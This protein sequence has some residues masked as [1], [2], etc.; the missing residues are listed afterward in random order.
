MRWSIAVL[1]LVSTLALSSSF[2]V[3]ERVKRQLPKAGQQAGKAGQQALQQ[4][5]Q[6]A[7]K[8]GQQA[9]QQAAQQAGKAGQQAGQQAAKAGQQAGQQAAKAGQQAGQ[10]AAKAGQQAGQ[11][12]GKAGQQ[13]GQQAGKAGQQAGQQAGKAGQQNAGQQAG[14]AGQQAGKQTVFKQHQKLNSAQAQQAFRGNL[15][16]ANQGVYD[17]MSSNK[18]FDMTKMGANDAKRMVGKMAKM[19]QQART[20]VENIDSRVKD[21][22][23]DMIKK[24]IGLDVLA[25]LSDNTIKDMGKNFT[26]AQTDAVCDKMIKQKS[27]KATMKNLL[28]GVDCLSAMDRKPTQKLKGGQ[29]I[30]MMDVLRGQKQPSQWSANDW[31]KALRMKDGIKTSDIKNMGNSQ[32]KTLVQGGSLKGVQ[33]KDNAQKKALDT[34]IK[35]AFGQPNT[36]SASTIQQMASG[37]TLGRMSRDDLKKL[38]KANIKQAASSLKNTKFDNP[39]KKASVGKQMVEAFDKSKAASWSASDIQNLGP[40]IRNDPKSVSKMSATNFK[41]ALPT[42]GADKTNLRQSVTMSRKIKKTSGYNQPKQLDATKLG[43][44]GNFAQGLG[45]NFLKDL[46]DNAV[47]GAL[48]KLKDVPFQRGDKRVLMDKIK[49]GNSLGA[50]NKFDGAKVKQ[51]G[52]LVAGL[53]AKDLKSIPDSA[54]DDALDDLKTNADD[55]DKAQCHAIVAKVKKSNGDK[56]GTK[57]KK[58]GK[59]M[60]KCVMKSTVQKIDPDDLDL[61]NDTETLDMTPSKGQAK[62]LF[63][64]VK[65]RLGDIK[66][67]ANFTTGIMRKLGKILSRGADKKDIDDLTADSTLPTVVEGLAEDEDEMDEAQTKAVSKKI[68]SFLQVGDDT[69]V[70]QVDESTV[71][72]V[73]KFMKH[74]NDSDLSRFNKTLRPVIARKIGQGCMAKVKRSD[75]TRLKNFALKNV[76]RDDTGSV[77]D[78]RNAATLDDNDVRD[79]GS[80]AC[81]LEE[82]DVKKLTKDALQKNLYKLQKCAFARKVGK[83]LF[84]RAKSQISDL[85]STKDNL[86]TCGALLKHAAQADL[87]KIDDD[88]MSEATPD[89]V[90]A[91]EEQDKARAKRDKGGHKD[92]ESKTDRD[93][94]KKGKKRVAAKALSALKKASSDLRKKRSTT[95]T[96]CDDLKAM[97]SSATSVSATDLGTLSNADFS[98]CAETL[99]ALTG[100]DTDQL[101]TLATKAK[102]AWGAV[103]TWTTEQVRQ[104]GSIIGGLASSE[105]STLDL[106]SNDAMASIGKHA[107][108]SMQLSAGFER[109]LSQAKSGSTST[110][111]ASELST[112]GH[113]ACGATTTHINGFSSSVYSDAASSIGALTTCESSQL[114]AYATKAKTAFGSDVTSWTTGTISTMGAVIGGLAKTDLAQ[115]SSD[116]ISAISPA[117]IEQIPPSNFAGF[118]T[119]QLSGLTTSQANAVTAQQQN[120]LSAEQRTSL[121]SAG[122]TYKVTDSGAAHVHVSIMLMLTMLV[123]LRL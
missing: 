49:K 15:K 110:V 7:G 74:F 88:V 103:N 107:F 123:F 11:Q 59:L 90:T 6:Q 31:G 53:T 100:W 91:D 102:A 122:A 32:L 12:A 10:Q 82:K 43:N 120:A 3:K 96:T 67:N 87:D 64:K 95:S 39:A 85:L 115:L 66:D 21:M 114:G 105:I 13:A 84:D 23:P 118:T 58:M 8:A 89:L 72:Q 9:L 37:E 121:T 86:L 76:K 20:I 93:E 25:G 63:K 71:E 77:T 108:D 78:R 51:L 111:T 70:A 1:V 27:N 98:D 60:K 41:A 42:L 65:A 81:G 40:F 2:T 69:Q 106:N 57:V 38:P 55:F 56:L 29:A 101:Q 33:L 119:T 18:K 73:G 14:K 46:P 24:D 79:L 112:V 113:F 26:N 34:K 62:M 35:A 50:L 61:E 17:K 4:A 5:A 44:M 36:W 80:L 99:G 45:K 28:K 19:P 83:A 48:S 117:S 92:E 68:R 109:W 97:G 30:V 116:Q 54:V 104:A 16:P 94:A 52:K 47:G 75:V 22:T